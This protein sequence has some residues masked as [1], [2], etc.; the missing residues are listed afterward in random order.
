MLHRKRG[1][2]LISKTSTMTMK[3]VSLYLAS[4][5]CNNSSSTNMNTL[6]RSSIWSYGAETSLGNCRLIQRYKTL[7]KTLSTSFYQRGFVDSASK[8]SKSAAEKLIPWYL[9]KNPTLT[10]FI[11]L[12][13]I[14]KDSW[15][16]LK[17]SNF[18]LNLCLLRVF[19]KF[20]RLNALKILHLQLRMDRF[21]H[22][23]ATSMVY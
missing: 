14:S 13:A 5:P 10:L 3:T 17:M 8:L 16:L 22:G 15:V 4:A 2:S 11:L 7:S 19:K 12:A 9:S 1:R 21:T 23:E 20:Q 18:Q 6:N